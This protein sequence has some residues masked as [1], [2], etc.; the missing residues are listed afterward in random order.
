MEFK[1]TDKAQRP[2]NVNGACF[3]CNQ[4]IGEEHKA[5]CVLIKK[6]VKVRL[7]IEY[8]I[9]VPA[10][11]DKGDIEFHRNESSWCANNVLDE[12]KEYKGKSGSCLCNFSI[13]EY[14]DENSKPYLKESSKG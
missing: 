4:T 2:A 6:K 10:F 3:F 11:W 8:E 7:T 12:L 1:V 5:D 13:F 14:L 9:E